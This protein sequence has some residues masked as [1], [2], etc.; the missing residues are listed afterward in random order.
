MKPKIQSDHGS[1]FVSREFAETL[2]HLGIAHVKIRPHT[3]Q[4]NAEIERCWR[5]IA[6][7]LDELELEDYNYAK[8]AIA[9]V[10]DQYNHVRLHSALSFLR[11][12]DYYRGN[13]ETLMDERHRRLTIAREL[14]KQENLKLR[15]RRLPF[16]EEKTVA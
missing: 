5:T 3:P 11:L 14:R 10:I 8:D 15:Q 12:T 9:R 16:M 7:K 6:E 1:C 4:D 2:Y 13:P